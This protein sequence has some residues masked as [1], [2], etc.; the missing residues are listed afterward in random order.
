VPTAALHAPTAAPS[1]LCAAATPLPTVRARSASSTKA[2]VGKRAGA[3]VGKAQGAPEA[4]LFK[5][6][7]P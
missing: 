5:K 1:A 3:A 2:A 6:A 7:Q 4:P